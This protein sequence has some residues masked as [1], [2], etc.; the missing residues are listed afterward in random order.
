VYISSPGIIAFAAFM[1]YRQLTSMVAFTPP[2]DGYPGG[3][4]NEETM[5]LFYDKQ[6]PACTCGSD[7][8]V[9]GDV[10]RFETFPD[11]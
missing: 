3:V 11:I 9:A 4:I 5:V 8:A 10:N 6:Q 7:R 1:A 2:A